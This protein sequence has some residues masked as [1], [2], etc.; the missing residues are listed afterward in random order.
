MRIAFSIFKVFPYGGIAR[1]LTKIVSACLARGHEVRIYA[2]AWEGEPVAG[3]EPVLLPSRGLRSHVRQRRFAAKVAEHRR[4]HPLD[5]LVGMNKM[6]DLDVYYAGDSCFEDKARTQRPWAYRLTPRYR[7]FAD[8]ERAVFAEDAGTRILTIAPRQDDVFRAIYGTPRYRFYDLPPGIERDRMAGNAEHAAMLRRELG[9]S[10]DDALLLFVGSGFVKKGLGRV[11]KAV[12]ALPG[13]I[14]VRVRL[15]VVGTDRARRFERLARRLGLAE[16]VRF[17]GGRDDVPDLLRAADAFTLP[18]KDEAAGM[19]ILEAA[20]AGLPVLVTANCGYA[21]FIADADAGIVTP[22]PFEQKR[23][24]ADLLRLLTSHERTVWA[25]NGRELGRDDSL[26]SMA[27]RAVDLLERFGSGREPL[28]V[29]FL[30]FRH[31]PGDPRCRDLLPAAVACRA[32]GLNVRI[33]SCIWAGDVPGNIELVRV[34]VAAMTTA[35]RMDRYR[36]WVAGALCRLPAA[37]VIDFDGARGA[38]VEPKPSSDIFADLPLG[39]GGQ[40]IAPHAA[41]D[42]LRRNLGFAEDDVVFVM[43]GGDLVSQ[44]VERLFTALGRLPVEDRERCRMLA[45]GRLAGSLRTAARVLGLRD[46]TQ[47]IETGMFWRDAIEAGDIF[48]D[49]AYA[50]SS[51]GWIF[52]ALAAGRAVLTHDWVAQAD[53]VRQADGGI[54]LEAPVGQ[55]ECNRAA[56]D[57]VTDSGLRE[58]CQANATAFGQDPARF[59]RSSCLAL[60]IEQLCRQAGTRRS[61]AVE[62]HRDAALSA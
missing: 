9:V 17:V 26:Y 12:A 50:P 15:V 30:A 2:M 49:L 4:S 13:A 41:S 40:P 37:C 42:V 61:A 8:F 31:I 51:N 19:V 55:A 38:V 34:P 59:G 5:L 39:L 20:I 56:L 62:A 16:R 6:P 23:F 45:V 1:D 22:L 57:L 28:L 27:P 21:P 60:R 35:A 48:V 46:R 29:T 33:Y 10:K 53:W 36:R 24:N 47:I 3:A 25:R 11:L 44:G 14:R 32:L 58:R 52:D 54:V 18:A 43:V 7:H